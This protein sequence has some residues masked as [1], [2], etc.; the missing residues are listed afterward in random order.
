MHLLLTVQAN[1]AEVIT[2]AIREEDSSKHI[3]E[4]ETT[5]SQRIGWSRSELAS[6]CRLNKHKSKDSETH[7]QGTVRH[8]NCKLTY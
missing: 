8:K 1:S 6:R 4:T 7:R 2:S 5:P 3:E